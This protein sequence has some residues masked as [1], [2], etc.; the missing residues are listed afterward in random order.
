VAGIG[1]FIFFV[2]LGWL[3]R[4]LYEQKKAREAQQ[5]ERV[6]LCPDGHANLPTYRFCGTC[7][8]ALPVPH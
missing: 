1:G 3:W 8:K 6:V 7:G 2:F 5:R 4:E